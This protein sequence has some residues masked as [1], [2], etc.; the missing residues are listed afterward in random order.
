MQFSVKSSKA[1]LSKIAFFLAFTLLSACTEKQVPY[2]YI[3]N[4][5]S[6]DLSVINT[7]TQQV[8]LT[9]KTGHRPVGIA[10]SKTG[11]K[12]FISN[13]E[14]QEIAVLDTLSMK[15]IAHIPLDGGPVGIATNND[16]ST[17]YV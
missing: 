13:S 17:V 10:L 2:A 7:E 9:I 3:T 11:N 1:V 4:Q 6:D 15:V 12:A 5:L 16:G 14:G 8:I